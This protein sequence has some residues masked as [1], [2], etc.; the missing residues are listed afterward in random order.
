MEMDS[1]MGLPP[2]E[3]QMNAAW[4]SISS[5]ISTVHKLMKAYTTQE[6]S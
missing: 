2:S 6:Q 3:E 1:G 5:T 4:F